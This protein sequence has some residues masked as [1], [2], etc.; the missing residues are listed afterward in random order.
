MPDAS[1]G[2]PSREEYSE[3]ERVAWKDYVAERMV[4]LGQAVDAIPGPI[5]PGEEG[6][7]TCPHC[8]G[9]LTWQRM[10]NGNVWLQCSGP[11]CIGPVHFNIPADR[12]WPASKAG[13][14][15]A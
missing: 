11:D 12:I 9:F 14:E 15:N 6:H 8:A 7:T 5:V 1:K 10:R 4:K 2:C 13:M 3:S